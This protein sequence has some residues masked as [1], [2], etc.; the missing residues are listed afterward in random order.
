M[1]QLLI[2]YTTLGCYDNLYVVLLLLHRSCVVYEHVFRPAYGTCVRHVPCGIVNQHSCRGWPWQ[3]LGQAY[4]IG[5][6]VV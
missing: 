4:A 1:L 2:C 3:E 6:A 5:E